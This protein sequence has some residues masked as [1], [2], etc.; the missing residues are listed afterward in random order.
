MRRTERILLFLYST[1][2]IVGSILAL[3]GLALYF[4]GI[5]G[6]YWLLIVIGLYLIGVLVTPRDTA[7]DLAIES[8]LSVDEIRNELNELVRRI[9]RR[10][11]P[12][13]LAKVESIKESIFSI[14]PLLADANAGDRNVYVIRQTA[15]AYL[16]EALEHYLN[17]PPAFAN[18][19]PIRDG[20]TARQL[21]HE[22][23]EILDRE[24]QELVVDISKN[25]TQKLL[26]HGR[27][28]EQKFGNMDLFGDFVPNKRTPVAPGG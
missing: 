12:E 28:L 4:T 26:A 3:V 18:V 20:K 24:M 9:R 8:Q 14:L 13:I 17:L 21:L 15:F 2:N 19:H 7:Y 10:L 22:Q 27:F 1:A 25:D 16:P 5:I 23:L 6:R 11:P